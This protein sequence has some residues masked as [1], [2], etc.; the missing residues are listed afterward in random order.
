MTKL[1]RPKAILFD[2]DGVLVT[3]EQL[4]FLAWQQLLRDMDL[5]W[6]EI[7]F[8]GLVGRTAPQILATLLNQF[9]PGWTSAD[10]DVDA[11]ALQKNDYYLEFA[12]TQLAPYPGVR[13]GLAWLK[14]V[15]IPCAVVSNA[16]SREL[17]SSLS[18]LHLREFFDVVLSRDDVPRPKPDPGPFEF[19]AASLGFSPEEC[20]AIDDSPTGLEGALLAKCVTASVTTNYP[21]S[22]LELPIPGRP[23][24]APIWIG[25]SMDD[26]FRWVASLPPHHPS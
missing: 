17:N 18:Q 16:R 24:L 15:G 26:F 7:H 14:S 10:Y 20:I 2:H 23:D 21:R 11:L 22:A 6:Q 25:E 1:F 5:P 3:S 12:K 4:H 13:E 9:R 8:D 19:A